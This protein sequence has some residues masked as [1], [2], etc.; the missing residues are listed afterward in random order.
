MSKMMSA[1][2][3]QTI[4]D[5]NSRR[6]RKGPG[7]FLMA[8]AV[9]LTL[10]ACDKGAENGP[11]QGQSMP[12]PQVG[13]VTVKAENVGITNELPGRLEAYRV[14]DVRARVAGVL[15]RRMFEEGSD[16]KANQQLFQIDDA[17][18]RASLQSAQAQL[19]Q[20]EANLMQTRSQAERYRPLVEVN[21]VSRQDYDNAVAAQKASEANIAAARAAI[22]TARINLGY[23]AVKSPI[24]GRIGRA[25]VTEG[26]LV[27]QGNATE[28]AVV[29][30]I[31]PMY[32][33]FTQPAVDTIRLQQAIRSGSYKSAGADGSVP[34][35]V[36]LD[37]GTVY[38]QEGRLLFTDLTVDETTGQVT[39]RAT[40]PNPDK[41]LLPG[42]YVRVRLEQV[43]V[44]NAFLV[45]QQAVTRTTSGDS[46]YVIN[47]E[48]VVEPRKVT[49][50]GRNGTNW[51]VTEGL[52]DGDRVMVDGFQKW[53][54]A[55]Q[56]AMQQ[57]AAS[58]QQGVPAVPVNPVP[59]SSNGTAEPVPAQE[60]SGQPAQSS[61]NNNEQGQT[62]QASASSS[63]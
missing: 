60:E 33:N 16:V 57:A 42:L 6:S 12:A 56:G 32:V 27:G 61:N 47:A 19:A 36:V 11:G 1:Q 39:L 41:L 51:I 44:E 63:N 23:A 26:A 50:T 22:T 30:Q 3:V 10:T 59:V 5:K 18:Y 53:Q 58:G 35:T 28:L 34:I 14:A 43:Q 31:D 4:N 9:A 25:L 55:M 46:L 24:D 40:L 20:A 29:Q 21:A 38:P 52:S 13:Y 45:P 17:P 7:A 37:D 15:E 49:I 2:E 62:A 54:M 48:N 8:V